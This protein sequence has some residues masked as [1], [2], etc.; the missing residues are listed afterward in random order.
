MI[1]TLDQLSETGFVLI[2]DSK[3]GVQLKIT[4][5]DLSLKQDFM[6]EGIAI[7]HVLLL[8]RMFSG[9]KVLMFV[10]TSTMR[11]AFYLLSHE[12]GFMNKLPF[13]TNTIQ[14]FDW[15]EMK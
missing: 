5:H 11:E 7:R 9:E 2:T 10:N 12:A 1:K 8:T 6:N 15:Q 14:D 4:A 13:D 3:E